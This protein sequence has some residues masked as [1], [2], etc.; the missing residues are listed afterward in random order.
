M[1]NLAQILDALESCYGEQAPG[2]P[3][4]PYLFLV[5][6]HCGYPPSEERCGRG[7]ECLSRD[8]GVTP[9]QLLAATSARVARAL[10][11]GGIVPELRAARLKVIAKSVRDD[12]A[13]NLHAALERLPLT[14]SR[15]VLKKFPG[16]GAPGAD[17]ILLFGGIAPVAAIPSACP[18]VLVR[19]ESGREPERYTATYTQAQRILA[20]QA[21]DGFATLTRAYLLLQRHGHSLC[22]RSN[23]KCSAC[24]VA[25]GCAYLAGT[26]RRRRSPVRRARA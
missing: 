25:D 20:A 2:W 3:T 23:P 10:K 26:A 22:K 6:W 19:I 18:H 8:V 21:G 5:W 24:P 12:H 7:F 15:A 9:Q 16:I 14:E 4:D 1:P 11:V 17:R 13:G